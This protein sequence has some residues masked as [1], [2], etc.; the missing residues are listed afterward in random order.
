MSAVKRVEKLLILADKRDVQA[1]T[2]QAQ[3]NKRKRRR[4]D[5]GEDEIGAIARFTEEG[6]EKKKRVGG[7][8]GEE[9]VVKG[10]GK[11]VGKVMEVGSWFQQRDGFEVRVRTGSVGALDDVEVPEKE[12]QEDGGADDEGGKMDVDQAEPGAEKDETGDEGNSEAAEKEA[13]A[14]SGTRIRYL[15]VLEVAVSLR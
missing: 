13:E 10:T 3:K 15:S 12:E 6:R 9:V 11:A 14:V 1:A 5:D 4:D 8:S 7:V 2:T